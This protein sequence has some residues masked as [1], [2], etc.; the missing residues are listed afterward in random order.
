MYC[1]ISVFDE[2]RGQWITKWDCGVESNFGDKQKSEAS[3][4]FKRAGFKWGIGVELYTAPF[5][6]VPADKC[7]IKNNR[8]YDKFIVEKIAI[9][10]KVI[11]AI[12]LKNSSKN[13]RAFVYQDEE[14]FRKR[15]K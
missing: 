12:S 10:N 14:Y 5:I 7:E 4:A 3:D 9:R 8:C 2:K 6:W 15:G 1:G 13:R 11:V